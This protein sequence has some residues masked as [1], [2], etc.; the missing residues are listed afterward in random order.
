MS[1]RRAGELRRMMGRLSE[2]APMAPEPE[3]LRDREP[4]R[5]Q[6]STHRAMWPILCA[7]VALVGLV[8]VLAPIRA[9]HQTKVAS[10]VAPRPVDV[11]LEDL[12]VTYVPQGFTLENDRT[13]SVPVSV[14]PD[15]QSP[16][17]GV[18]RG[19]AGTI[20][21][22]RYG[23][24]DAP[25]RR[26]V[27]YVMV[28]LRP[29]RIGTLN[30]LEE[31]V[32]DARPTRVG[33][34]AA[35]LSVPEPGTSGGIQIRWVESPHVVVMLSSRGAVSADEVRQMAEGVRFRPSSA[36][37]PPGPTTD[38][39]TSRARSEVRVAAANA[40]ETA[41]LATRTLDFL[42][43]EGYTT[44][45]A[46]VALRLSDSSAVHFRPGFEAEAGTVARLLSIAETSVDPSPPPVPNVD[47]ADIVVVLGQDLVN[48]I[49]PD[50]SSPT[51]SALDTPLGRS[52]I[53]PDGSGR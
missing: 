38:I 53:R 11:R 27:V 52:V 37:S 36:G 5:R 48:R 43:G 2:L 45:S 28:L 7:T 26:A 14:E 40:S 6:P 39:G 18:P 23:R 46:V 31:Q 41:G 42:R 22:Q 8:A 17:R 21:T 25:G 20:R 47:P 24:G 29:D 34:K 19:S 51:T 10:G 16:A 33:E 15:P 12:A 13:E 9:D 3:E 1:D 30:E 44:L 32:E 50:R 4:S 35:V 49:P